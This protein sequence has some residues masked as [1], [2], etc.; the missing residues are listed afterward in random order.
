[1]KLLERLATDVLKDEYY[2]V[3]FDRINKLYYQELF[4]EENNFLS[5][6]ELIDLM[7]FC[8][9]L[10][11]S[12]S[13]KHKNIAYKIVTLLF[14]FYKEDLNF[15]T[16]SS[17]VL[18]KIGNFP[19]L[20]LLDY[21]VT[22]PLDREI[23]KGVKK[24]IQH[25]KDFENIY[26]TDPQYLL[27]HQ[28]K[29][30]PVFSFSGPTSMGKSFMM[31]INIAEQ[32]KKHNKP[33][34]VV[35]VPTRALIHQFATEI[36][37][38]LYSQLEDENYT[39]LTNGNL[40]GVN[41][42]G[43][44]LIMVLT[45]ERL[46]SFLSEEGYPSIDCLFVDE[47]HKLASDQ[48]KRSITL[49]TAVERTIYANR[50][51]Q[52][53]FASPNVSNPEVF[54]KLFNK[55]VEH[56][57][58]SNESPVS[59]Q[60]FF[61]DLIT[62][63]VDHYT[64]NGIKEYYPKIVSNQDNDSLDL[65]NL[66]SQ[67]QSNLIYC[68]SRRDAVAKARQ[69]SQ[70]YG[71]TSLTTYQ[72]RRIQEAIQIIKKIVHPEYYLIDCLK[73]G[74]AYHFGSL[75][76]VLRYNIEQL[77]KDGIIRYLFC[78]STLLEGVNLPAKNVF[79][80]KNK[81][82]IR[83]FKKVDFWN[84]AGRAGRLKYELS[85]NIYCI[86]DEEKDWKKVNEYLENKEQIFMNPTVSNNLEN[87]LNHITDAM[88]NKE[89]KKINKTEQDIVRY[90]ANIIS[91]DTLDLVTEYQSP[92]INKLIQN[93]QEKI[94][95]IAKEKVQSIEIPYQILKTNQ[96]MAVEQQESAFQYI[97]KN[98]HNFKKTLFPKKINYEE[99]LAVLDLFHNI[100]KWDQYERR[101]KSKNSLK[102]FALLMNN[103]INGKSLNELINQSIDFYSKTKRKIV[104]YDESNIQRND[105]F[106]RNSRIQV[107]TL[108][109]DLIKEIEEILRF[110]IQKYVNHYYL[111]LQEV[112]GK[113][114][115]GAN[116]SNYLEYGTRSMVVIILQNMGLSRYVANLLS[117]EYPTYF[118]VNDGKLIK[119][120]K[121]SL[122]KALEEGSIEEQEVRMFL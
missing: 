116:W 5:K 74:V 115:A 81:N 55:E 18:S 108:I 71:E 39:V 43:L 57:F 88:L 44:N 83:N 10:S 113:E 37:K 36:K 29:D 53:F 112:Y 89:I 103:W 46:L 95:E 1:M 40:E 9:L 20:Q 94:I 66:L 87:N 42:E 65:I 91:I 50:N 27:Y 120:Q 4:N 82:G 67:E 12:T 61:V 68:H 32:M 100:Y 62:K 114:Q 31:K 109:N 35:I 60:L 78:T 99:C 111:I 13:S 33:N 14:P 16:V 28:M 69:F 75:P 70:E 25:I 96:H 41:I 19:A 118:Q 15:K 56:V 110:T 84:L 7:R 86:R 98:E 17:A 104:Y 85:G 119:I 48:D 97:I 77:F 117:N 49:Y 58:Y 26:L 52:L 105:F 51:V 45:P 63:Q 72:K 80:L 92:V 2:N 73:R 101:L 8:D 11:N 106:V 121:E 47:A 93:K 76:Q 122:L 6:K 79:I 3:L 23:E 107:N 24:S 22:L 30:A 38:D 59:Q 54:L 90:L 64:E 102:Y 34:I 21:D